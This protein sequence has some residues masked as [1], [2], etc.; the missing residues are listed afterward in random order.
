MLPPLPGITRAAIHAEDRSLCRYGAAPPFLPGDPI[1]I[2]GKAVR[3]WC[4][5]SVVLARLRA[6]GAAHVLGDSSGNV[7]LPPVSRPRCGAVS[8]KAVGQEGRG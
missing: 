6:Q 5:A 2:E 3:P 8:P 1:T 7:A 4:G